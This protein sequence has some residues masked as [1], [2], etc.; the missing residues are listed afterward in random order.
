MR[1]YHF[2][3]FQIIANSTQPES[4]STS[5]LVR[6]NI[7]RVSK[8]TLDPQQNCLL[9]N[10]AAADP[11]ERWTQETLKESPWH[12][13][14]TGVAVFEQAAWTEIQRAEWKLRVWKGKI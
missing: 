9:G 12:S 1:P 3:R 4:Q 14:G 8:S 7:A 5:S 2:Q 11:I 6:D 13:M 10:E